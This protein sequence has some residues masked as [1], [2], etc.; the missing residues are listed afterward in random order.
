[1]PT[2]AKLFK[3]GHSLAV[4]LPRAYRLPGKEVA[5]HREGDRIVLEPLVKRKW[6]KDFFRKI[7][8]SDPAFERPPQGALPPAVTLGE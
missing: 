5:I 6:P 2:I 7:R 4:R 1:V 3:N 8:I